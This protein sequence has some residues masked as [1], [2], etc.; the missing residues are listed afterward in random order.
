MSTQLDMT[1]LATQLGC[2]RWGRRSCSWRPGT[3]VFDPSLYGVE[4]IDH[5]A[6]AREF[7]AQHHYARTMPPARLRVG[8]YRLNGAFGAELVGVC[9][10]S[11]P[12]SQRTIPMRLPGLEA[13][14]GV[15]LGRLVLLDSVPANG[16]SWFVAR[17]LKMLRAELPGV[18]G[19]VSFADPVPRRTSEG[20]LVMPGHVGWV[21]QALEGHPLSRSTARTLWLDPRGCV[22]SPR[23]LQ[24][25]RAGERGA[26]GAM[27][28]LLDLGAPKRAR[29]EDAGV[30]L[31]R[32]LREG[33]FRRVHHP[34]N[35]CY[36]WTWAP[37][38][39]AALGPVNHA[40]YTK[41]IEEEA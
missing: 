6:T 10:F 20:A 28:H 25:I 3:E 2:Q 38:T 5:D 41:R 34:G 7:I 30:W 12:T 31:R 14:Q 37:A 32:A 16:E 1:T 29:H 23:T 39:R 18:L 33:P 4:L 21:Y 36:G 26:D 11:V 27:R 13:S 24:K 15:E 22:L 8:L 17:A 19:V 35:L 40:A 9:V